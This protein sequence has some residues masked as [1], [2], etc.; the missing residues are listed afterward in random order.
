[1]NPL[2]I[3]VARRRAALPAGDVAVW[4]SIEDRVRAVAADQLDALCPPG[5]VRVIDRRPQP[6][7]ECE[8]LGRVED[9]FPTSMD[10][11]G[12]LYYD[13]PCS[14]CGGRGVADTEGAPQ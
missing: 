4:W 7:P 1:M 3:L 11:G 5:S 12:H 9:A 8:G 6:C 13:A 2:E 10:I 14:A